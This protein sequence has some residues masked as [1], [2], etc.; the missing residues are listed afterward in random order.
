MVAELVQKEAGA[1]R[2]AVAGPVWKEGDEQQAQMKVQEWKGSR[3]GRWLQ[4]G[5]DRDLLH[6]LS[7]YPR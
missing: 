4:M 7:L 3:L 2:E 5:K 6:D 1:R